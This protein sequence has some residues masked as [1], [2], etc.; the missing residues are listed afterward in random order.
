MIN[1]PVP[2]KYPS[3]KTAIAPSILSADLLNLGEKIKQAQE[4][5]ADWLHIDIMDGHFVP[6]AATAA[7]AGLANSDGCREMPKTRIQRDAPL[8]CVP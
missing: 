3:G 8:I 5:G 7:K 1:L 2:A 4:A 6:N